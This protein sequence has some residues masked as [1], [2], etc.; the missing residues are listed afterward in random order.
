MS[1]DNDRTQD[2][3]KL[4]LVTSITTL[5]FSEL[6]CRVKETPGTLKMPVH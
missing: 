5:L 4:L 1:I 2:A 3:V 6:K